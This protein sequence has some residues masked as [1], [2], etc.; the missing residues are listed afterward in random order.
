[1]NDTTI[2]QTERIIDKYAD[3]V[4]GA[5]ESLAHTLEVP[6]E[7]VYGLLVRQQ[8]INSVYTIIVLI[9]GIA[10][11]WL[12]GKGIKKWMEEDSF[13]EGGPVVIMGVIGVI[14]AL[15]GIFQIDVILTGFFNPEYG[16]IQEIKN[17][18][19]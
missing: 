12:C 9:T 15:N 16:A 18:I 10:L 19:N 8:A 3:K 2:T 11:C 17:L 4:A 13:M 6:A 1:M 7:H 14:C 5:L